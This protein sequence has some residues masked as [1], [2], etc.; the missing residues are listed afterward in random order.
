MTR[1]STSRRVGAALTGI[2]ILVIAAAYAWPRGASATQTMVTPEGVTIN[3]YVDGVTP[4]Q[5]YEV[6]LANGLQAHVRLAT[7]NVRDGGF[8]YASV[9]ADCVN[10]RCEP[11]PASIEI[12]ARVYLSQPNY[13]IGHEY[14]H[15]WSNYYKWTKWQGSWDTY[16][17][18]RGLFGDPRLDPFT[19]GCLNPSEIIANDYQQLFGA[20]ETLAFVADCPDYPPAS[21]VDG[22]R[23][24]LALTW[25]NDNPPPGYAATPNQP[26][27]PS[28]A[29]SQTPTAT[30]MPTAVP[31]GTQT[32]TPLPTPYP[33]SPA[34]VAT[35]TIPK[36][37]QRFIAPASGVVEPTVYF[38]K[39]TKLPTTQ[40]MKGN[41]YWA[42]G[43]ATISILSQ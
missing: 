26:T 41:S 25:T 40:V 2:F 33:T 43:P 28:P 37:W 42:R 38:S 17:A 7:V 27:S 36:G 16:L 15:V 31:M 1:S 18:A 29:P 19:V 35:I 9:G 4:Q 8:T 39:G 30:V 6:L 20:V 23:D 14:G 34:P 11:T 22:L 13:T 10:G 3:V 24:F 32:P 21:N 5:V 12:N